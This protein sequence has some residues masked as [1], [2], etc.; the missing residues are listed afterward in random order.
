MLTN[1]TRTRT[2]KIADNFY[3][4]KKSTT[5]SNSGCKDPARGKS[6]QASMVGGIYLATV[7]KSVIEAIADSIVN[8][9]Q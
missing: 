2:G 6:N 9:Q 8:S 7:T 3:K 5:C 1:H 4:M